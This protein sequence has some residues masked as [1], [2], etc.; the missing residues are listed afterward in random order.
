MTNA[1]TL[2]AL[3]SLIQLGNQRANDVRTA[4]LTKRLSSPVTHHALMHRPNVLISSSQGINANP[5]RALLLLPRPSGLV[6]IELINQR[7]P[8]KHVSSGK[9]TLKS[10]MLSR[11]MDARGFVAMGQMPG[12]IQQCPTLVLHNNHLIAY[13]LKSKAALPAYAHSIRELSTLSSDK[14]GTLNPRQCVL[15]HR[16]FEWDNWREVIG[17]PGWEALIAHEEAIKD[18]VCGRVDI[19]TISSLARKVKCPS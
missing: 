16:Y 8:Y 13:Q 17:E 19:D 6:G 9:G 15:C 14:L 2:W 7:L 3:N 5:R 4:L 10:R 18:V 11:Y 1:N 12:L